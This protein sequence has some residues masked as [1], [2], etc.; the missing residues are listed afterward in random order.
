MIVYI[1]ISSLRFFMDFGTETCKRIKSK[2]LDIVGALI[3][4]SRRQP[5][6]ISEE[7]VQQLQTQAAIKDHSFLRTIFETLPGV[8]A[9]R[10]IDRVPKLSSFRLAMHEALQSAIPHRSPRNSDGFDPERRKQTPESPAPC[11]SPMQE[12]FEKGLLAPI[13]ADWQLE[14]QASWQVHSALCFPLFDR[15]GDTTYNTSVRPPCQ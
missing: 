14:E 5:G 7:Y 2:S 4:A 13:D 1:S 10:A 3:R 8:D 12:L 11:L 9:E 15:I 6:F